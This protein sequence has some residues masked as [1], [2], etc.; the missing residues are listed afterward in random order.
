MLK[1]TLVVVAAMS[2]ML[3]CGCGMLGGVS[4]EEMESVV[5]DCDFYMEAYQDELN[6]QIELQDEILDLEAEVATLEEEKAALE[7]ELASLQGGVSSGS[8]NNGGSTVED[9]YTQPFVKEA[10]DA[11][12]ESMKDSYSSTYKDLG[13][14]VSGNTFT[15]W[16]QYAD[17]LSNPDAVAEQLE[18]S[19]TED[20]LADVVADVE[21][22]CGVTGITCCYIYY[23]ADGSII[24]QDSYSTE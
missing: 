17:Q 10:L 9:Y 21:A 24:Y 14:D 16:F 20:M 15:Y 18:A 1:R 2:T 12:I 22:E 3:L 5:A 8:N 4:K 11:Q 23:N 19:L 6:N 13:Y 7:E